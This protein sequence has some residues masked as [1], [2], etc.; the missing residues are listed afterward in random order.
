MSHA[1]SATHRRHKFSIAGNEYT[2]LPIN[3]N[4]MHYMYSDQKVSRPVTIVSDSNNLVEVNNDNV[5]D[6]GN[7]FL[8]KD[9]LDFAAPV[10]SSENVEMMLNVDNNKQALY[11]SYTRRM[12]DQIISLDR[13]D[14]L[15]TIQNNYKYE[16]GMFARA[17]NTFI[18][19]HNEE[20]V[21]SIHCKLSSLLVDYFTMLYCADVKRMDL[22]GQF[23]SERQLQ[24]SKII[25]SQSLFVNALNAY[26]N[27]V[28][29]LTFDT[30]C[31]SLR[32]ISSISAFALENMVLNEAAS[33]DS[34]EI[35]HFFT[36]QESNIPDNIK[37]KDL[38][39]FFWKKS[40]FQVQFSADGEYASYTVNDVRYLT[41][42]SPLDNTEEATTKYGDYILV[43]VRP[44]SKSLVIMDFKVKT[45]SNKPDV[46]VRSFS[47]S[48]QMM[49]I[50]YTNDYD[51]VELIKKST[52][53]LLLALSRAVYLPSEQFVA[54]ECDYETL[55][56][57]VLAMHYHTD[58][59]SRISNILNGPLEVVTVMDA[60]VRT[61][62]NL[63]ALPEE[64]RTPSV[65][66]NFWRLGELQAYIVKVTDSL[67]GNGVS[68]D[69]ILND[70][71]VLLATQMLA[72]LNE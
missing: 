72:I 11:M 45:M 54:L 44:L 25:L 40:D 23:G 4:L 20:F 66:H 56:Q 33:G 60:F 55:T 62:G 3:M 2:L 16:R 34:Y 38:N 47:G 61:N 64:Q 26:F 14:S 58:V 15:Q 46:A 29:D 51:M 71:S 39:A 31:E 43:N 6:L 19:N 18:R 52:R 7:L 37:I 5:V 36:K 21:A 24:E 70:I 8:V 17:M 59:I 68:K 27:T 9:K 32:N 13:Q 28:E 48:P 10:I 50:E 63:G 1:S 35:V 65:E 41:I 12:L 22:H 30:V 49:V 53:R 67:E 69:M 57:Y 42:I